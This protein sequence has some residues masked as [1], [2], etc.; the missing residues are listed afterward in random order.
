[1]LASEHRLK[2]ED[3]F[4]SIKKRGKLYQ[5]Q[6]FGIAVIKR[7]EKGKSRFGFVVSKKIAK[8]AVHRNRIK[9]ALR[10]A[11]RRNLNYFP[12]GIDAVILTKKSI[13]KKTT[14]EIM[15]ELEKF[16]RETKWK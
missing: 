15:R 10:E 5:S 16:S 3:T 4:E 12:K 8:S 1:M 11:V 7:T 13:F 2:G 14:E 9:R 6:D